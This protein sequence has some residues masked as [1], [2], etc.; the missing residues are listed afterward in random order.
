MCL[1][2][3]APSKPISAQATPLPI[4]RWADVL[5]YPQ[6]KPGYEYLECDAVWPHFGSS[7]YSSELLLQNACWLDDDDL[8]MCGTSCT[9]KLV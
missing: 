5:C 8:P 7:E 2:H 3:G 9:P 4:P 6:K 1:R